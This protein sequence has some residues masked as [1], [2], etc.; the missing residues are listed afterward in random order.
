MFYIGGDGEL[1]PS[2]ERLSAE[3][4]ATE[5]IRFTGRLSDEDLL[6]AYQAADLFVLPTLALECF[7]LISIEAMS[8]GC[9]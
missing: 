4:G 8:F 7:G 9:P 6:L 5:K 1:R 2:L 3:L